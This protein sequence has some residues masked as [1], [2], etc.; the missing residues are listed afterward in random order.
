MPHVARVEGSAQ[1]PVHGTADAEEEKGSATRL[2]TCAGW[3]VSCA[4]DTAQDV[5]FASALADPKSADRRKA[6]F[7]LTPEQVD[8]WQ[9][10]KDGLC[11]G[12]ALA[13]MDHSHPVVV[14]SDACNGGYGGAILVGPHLRPY[15]FFSW[16]LS[17]A[18]RNYSVA[19]REFQAGFT[20]MTRNLHVLRGA[21]S[22]LWLTDHAN[23]AHFAARS[24]L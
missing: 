6:P 13:P 23:A 4:R 14:V 20:I 18:Q 7:L 3:G 17:D 19:D 2:W 16:S 11:S 21:H 5:G 12:I 24:R 9:A 10:L 15:A 1:A 22:I 8:A